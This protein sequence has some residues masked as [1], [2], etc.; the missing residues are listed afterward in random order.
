MRIVEADWALKITQAATT[1]KL[2]RALSAF[3]TPLIFIE[4]GSKFVLPFHYWKIL[5][6]NTGASELLGALRFPCA[7]HRT[8][9]MCFYGMHCS[10][11]VM[12]HNDEF[13]IIILH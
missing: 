8:F 4:T 11:Y 3:H 7:S 1:S 12:I 9:A 2:S 5:Y 13:G 10:Q 6:I